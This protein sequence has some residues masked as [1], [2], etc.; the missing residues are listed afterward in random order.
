MN[1]MQIN[2]RQIVDAMIIREL[3]NPD[4]YNPNVAFRNGYACYTMAGVRELEVALSLPTRY[5]RG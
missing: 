2:T 5:E 4:T 3:M 1:T